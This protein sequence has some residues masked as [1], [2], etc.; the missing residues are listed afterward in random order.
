MAYKVYLSPTGSGNAIFEG[1][2]IGGYTSRDG[3]SVVL[4][5]FSND[6]GYTCGTYVV[7]AAGAKALRD[8]LA[9]LLERHSAAA[10]IF[11][12]ESAREHFTLARELD[13]APLILGI[14]G[15]DPRFGTSYH[16]GDS[17]ALRKV[18][19]EFD[20]VLQTLTDVM[21]GKGPA[22]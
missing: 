12:A 22:A 4:K 6:R 15:A 17:E 10:G 9:A 8:E 14:I 13:G 21:A 5:F 18:L 11:S 3:R 1:D 7:D 20:A 2:V 19:V 16:R